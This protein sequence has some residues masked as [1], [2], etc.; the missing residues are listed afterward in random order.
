M[1]LGGI[2]LHLTPLGQERLVSY[3]FVSLIKESLVLIML[4]KGMFWLGLDI[5][6]YM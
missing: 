5:K 3:F 4:I 2:H 6:L 1:T